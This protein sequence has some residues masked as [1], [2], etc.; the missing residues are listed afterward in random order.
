MTQ[1]AALWQERI[2]EWRASG[3]SAKQFCQDKEFTTS[4]LRQWVYRFK[5]E[6]EAAPKAPE[7]MVRVARVVREATA[8][9]APSRKAV[10]VR[11]P[12]VVEIGGARICVR[13]GFDR[14]TLGAVIELLTGSSSDRR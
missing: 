13:P 3:L 6:A 9:V 10:L 4:A 7:P 11:E 1:R 8:R 14:A 2:A 12:L 5:R